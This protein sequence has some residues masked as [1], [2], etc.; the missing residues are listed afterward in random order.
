MFLNDKD[1]ILKAADLRDNESMFIPVGTKKKQMKWTTILATL[2]DDFCKNVDTS[3]SLEVVKTF[4]DGKLWIKITKTSS[5]KDFFVKTP[6][7]TV[8]RLPVSE[9]SVK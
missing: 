7:G 9:V 8:K 4:Q 1:I 5:A 3:I 6:E 2:A